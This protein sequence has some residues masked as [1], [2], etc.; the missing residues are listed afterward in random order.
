MG[1]QSTLDFGQIRQ[2]M[3]VNVV[4]RHHG[5]V[6]A[7]LT[8]PKGVMLQDPHCGMTTTAAIDGDHLAAARR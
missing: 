2:R 6:N 3:H 1:C 5:K 7:E 4:E 8:L